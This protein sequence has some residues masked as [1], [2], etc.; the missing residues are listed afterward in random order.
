[1]TPMSGDLAQILVQVERARRRP[2]PGRRLATDR[3]VAGE[4]GLE[5]TL[6][7]GQLG[8]LPLDI[9]HIRGGQDGRDSRELYLQRRRLNSGPK[10]RQERQ[11]RT[12][13]LGRDL[14]G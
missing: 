7:T 6:A 3:L 12:D 4:R 13:G 1:M 11:D 14:E 8:Q 5:D 10:S 2:P 9:A